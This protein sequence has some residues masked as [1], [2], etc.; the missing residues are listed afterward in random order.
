VEHLRLV[1]AARYRRGA[2]LCV[3]GQ[4]D[5]RGGAARSDGR[6]HGHEHQHQ[7]HRRRPRQWGRNQPGDQRPAARRVPEGARLHPGRRR[8]RGRPRGRGPGRRS[9]AAV[10]R[11]SC[12]ASRTGR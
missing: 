5:H 6:R 12:W 3:H 11:V 10:V 7:E 4:P 8:V 2:R 9:P 1:G